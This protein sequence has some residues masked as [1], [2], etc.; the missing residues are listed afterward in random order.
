MQIT[1]INLNGKDCVLKYPI[2]IDYSKSG[3]YHVLSND[4]FRI[5]AISDNL[6]ECKVAIIEEFNMVVDNYIHDPDYALTKC[7]I[8]LRD[9]IVRRI[10]G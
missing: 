7:A 8:E 3:K 6:D 1:T 10:Y 9:N 4:E 2:D 5:Y